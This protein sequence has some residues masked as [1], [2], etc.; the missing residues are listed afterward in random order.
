MNSPAFNTFANIAGRGIG[1]LAALDTIKSGGLGTYLM[2]RQRLM[3]DPGFRASLV[4]SPFSAG[5]FGVSGETGPA[6]APPGA[7]PATGAAGGVVQPAEFVGPPPPGVGVAAPGDFPA[8]TAYNVPGYM[9]GQPRAWM[10]NLPPYDPEEALKQQAFASQQQAVTGG[11]D[12]QRG[13]AK[14]AVGIMP[15]E[16]ETRAVLGQAATIQRAAGAGSTVG[17]KFPGMTVQIGS[18]YSIAPLGEEE[19]STPEQARQAAA[20]HGP[21]W[22]IGPTVH[23]GWKPVAPPT[24]PQLLP[25]PPGAPPGLPPTTAGPI[26]RGTIKPPPLSPGSYQ[27]NA[28][29]QGMVNRGWTP[30]ESAAAAGNVHI[31]SAFIPGNVAPGGDSGLIQWAGPRLAGLQSYASATG[32]SWKDPE[33]QMDWLDME[34]SGES[35]KWG[36]SDER[37]NFR[38][39]FAAGGTPQEMARGF[40]QF[41]ERPRDLSATVDQRMAAAGLYAPTA[42]PATQVTTTSPPPASAPVLT[43]GRGVA[44]AAEPPPG[45]QVFTP[46]AA[47]PTFDPNA[48]VPHTVVSVPEAA[49]A[50]G[51]PPAAP[52]TPQPP[53]IPVLKPTPPPTALAPAATEPRPAAVLPGIPVDPSTGLPL[54]GRTQEYQGGRTETYAAPETGDVDTTLRLRKA[55]VTDPRLATPDQIANYRQQERANA[56]QKQV[57]QAD[58]TRL[59]RGMSETEAAAE[60]R[61]VLMK[62]A[63]DRFVS[64]YSD[65]ATRAQ[66]LGVGTWPWQSVVERLGWRGAK[67]IDDFRGGFAPFSLESL[68]DEKGK[69]ISP[70]FAPL[71][72]IA[73]S[74]KDSPAAFESHLQQ[75][76]DALDDEIAMR[77]FVRTAPSGSVTPEVYQQ[78][79]D[80]L[81]QA[82]T[83]RR[84]AALSPPPSAAPE[85]APPPPP[86]PAATTWAPNWVR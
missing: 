58:I 28:F 73:P 1:V 29:V 14:T 33:A 62:G 50:I 78:K 31:E 27:P 32:R 46:P 30:E 25:P 19:F 75:F 44:Y 61:L 23:G 66:F 71:A 84:L 20:A 3:S 6:P 77:S 5:I 63:A 68:T 35:T 12:V 18:P 24:G 15:T 41:V 9:P 80:E 7:L 45:A 70:D 52:E 60:R 79:L 4:G 65:P 69:A 54:K 37:D 49:G 39:A 74:G 72:T 76:R 67:A 16:A 26:I 11:S 56:A 2:N 83:D 85:A 10:P 86:P 22:T 82:R 59:E 34:R 21:G 51:Y 36:G 48:V 47:A 8:A 55:G 43:G 64:N 38:K 81:Q 13:L 42:Q 40:G 17:V 53:A 57:D